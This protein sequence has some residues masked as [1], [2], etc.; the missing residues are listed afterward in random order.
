MS[1]IFLEKPGPGGSIKSKVNEE[2]IYCSA[3][4]KKKRRGEKEKKKKKCSIRS[5]KS[6]K[7]EGLWS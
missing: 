6:G 3:K 2:I 5:K 7:I 4:S 1:F